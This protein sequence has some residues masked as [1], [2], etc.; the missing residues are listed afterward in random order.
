MDPV[1]PLPQI[2]EKLTYSTGCFYELTKWLAVLVIVLTLVH[3]FIATIFIIEGISMEPDFFN[4][5][6]IIANRFQYTF[7]KPEHGDVAMLKFPGDPEH[8]KYIKRI[9]G[10]PGDTVKIQDGTVTVNNNRLNEPYIS[11]GVQ[12]EPNM[13]ITLKDDEYFLMG[14]NR[15]NSNDSRVWG[16]ASKRHLIGKAWFVLWPTEDFGKVKVYKY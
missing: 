11:I 13:E 7:G 3:F 6:A 2:R 5:E 10:L 16:V 9:I 1:S 4:G 15:P 12:T 8:K 14:D